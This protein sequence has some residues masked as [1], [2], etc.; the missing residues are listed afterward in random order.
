MGWLLLV[1]LVAWPVSELYVTA[2]VADQ[3]GWGSTLVLLLALSVL[4]LIVLRAAT[5]RT[6]RG[7]ESLRPQSLDPTRPGGASALRSGA[8]AADTSLLF[9]AGVLLLVP[10]FVTGALGLLLLVP[11]VR[12]VLLAVTGGFVTRR[13]QRNET[14]SAALVRFRLWSGGDVVPGQV[15]GTDPTGPRE[16]PDDSDPSGGPRSPRPELPPG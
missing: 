8:A 4:G 3:L 11:P 6:R 13:V 15:V 5:R 14:A 1:L 12:T 10:G 16:G 2:L 7:L 9:L